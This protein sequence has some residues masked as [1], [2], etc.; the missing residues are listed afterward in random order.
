MCLVLM[1]IMGYYY[2]LSGAGVISAITEKATFLDEQIEKGTTHI[3]V[4]VFSVT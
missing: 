4:V 1:S 2:H 3:M